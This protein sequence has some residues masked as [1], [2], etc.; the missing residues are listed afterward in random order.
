[1]TDKNAAGA[2]VHH[3]GYPDIPRH[4]LECERGNRNRWA[5]LV[6]S[7]LPDGT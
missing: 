7:V 3:V 2:V 1:M 4:Y 5:L 6:Y